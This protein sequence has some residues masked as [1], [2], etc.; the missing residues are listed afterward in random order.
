MPTSTHP[1]STFRAFIYGEFLRIIRNTSEKEEYLK[2]SSLF[3]E[4]LL[5]RGY[6]ED[7]IENIRQTVSHENRQKILEETGNKPDLDKQNVPLVFTTKYTGYISPKQIKT[8]LLQHWNLI[9]NNTELNKTFNQPP[10]IAFKRSTNIQDTLIKSKSPDDGN[11]EILLD[12][13]DSPWK[14]LTYSNNIKPLF[15]I[16]S[17]YKYETVGETGK[18]CGAAFKSQVLTRLSLV[19]SLS[20]PRVLL[21]FSYTNTTKIP[22]PIFIPQRWTQTTI[23]H[24]MIIFSFQ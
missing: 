11:L 7:F 23:K 13:V 16:F 19:L 15:I 24:I 8:S 6:T 9:T 22:F 20:T 18:V 10:I 14:H 2:T 5:K 17:T 12:L 21:P 3:V 4:R 1:P